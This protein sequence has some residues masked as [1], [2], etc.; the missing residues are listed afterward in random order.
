MARAEEQELVKR[1]DWSG[2]LK[3]TIGDALAIVEANIA[4]QKTDTSIQERVDHEVEIA[5]DGTITNT[6]TLTRVHAGVKGELFKGANNV[7]Y[8]RVYVPMGSQ[9]LEATGFEAPW[10]SDH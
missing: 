1:Y 5:E 10:T 9:L 7:S 2:T 4:G 6:V 8:V 3:P